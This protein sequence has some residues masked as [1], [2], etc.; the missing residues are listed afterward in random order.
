MS[1][2]SEEKS[3]R[4]RVDAGPTLSLMPLNRTLRTVTVTTF[5]Y[6]TRAV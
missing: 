3:G 1:A 2:R 4:T 5:I 6:V